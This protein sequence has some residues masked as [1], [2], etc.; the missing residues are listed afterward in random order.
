MSYKTN[1]FD[2]HL[3]ENLISK[4]P[5]QPRD[6]ARL[7]NYSL[8]SDEIKDNF[9]YQLPDL[10]D[11]KTVL[12]FNDSRVDPVRL[13]FQLGTVSAE[14]LFLEKSNDLWKVM[15]R[16]GKKFKLGDRI[17]FAD[18][19]ADIVQI[20]TDGYRLVK[21]NLNDLELKN[22]LDKFGKMPVP[23]Y[24]KG[25]TYKERD[26]NTVY[27][28]KSGSVAA[29]TAGLHFTNELI[30]R[31][32]SK[33]IKIEYVTLKVGLGTFLPIKAN[34]IRNHK[35]HTEEYLINHLTAK[36]LNK[37][38]QAGYKVMPVGTTSLRVLESNYSTDA[39]F[40][41]GI[42]HTNIFIFPGYK[43]KVV[44]GLITNFHLPK[45]TLLMLVAAMIG[46]NAL[47]KVYKYAIQ[48]A[49]KFYSFG[50]GML[51]K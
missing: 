51:I 6:S 24:I 4:S 21:L 41:A 37:Y 7:L 12:V 45:S 46:K 33:G 30:A 39:G 48:K 43:W 31:L 2:F 26:Y 27:A 32:I 49:Y 3:P 18:L 9:F 47:E 25:E 17:K 36:R 14:M 15:V 22:F 28:N 20:D 5:A 29:P 40:N 8:L 38:V 10:L 42:F 50:D 1:D 44:N 19:E 11:E 23:P 34:D 16:P 35:M 13:S